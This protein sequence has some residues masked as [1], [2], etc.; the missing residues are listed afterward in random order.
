MTCVAYQSVLVRSRPGTSLG[1][2]PFTEIIV[3]GISL[4]KTICFQTPGNV[5]SILNH[6]V[7]YILNN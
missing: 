2:E 7:W 1:K 6:D 5:Y 4:L 3:T